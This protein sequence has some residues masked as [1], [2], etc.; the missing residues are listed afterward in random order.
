[1]GRGGR[2]FVLQYG[3]LVGLVRL[4]LDLELACLLE[5]NQI[6]ELLYSLKCT[7]KTYVLSEHEDCVLVVS[8]GSNGLVELG[9]DDL[10]GGWGNIRYLEITPTCD[11]L[12]IIVGRC[13]EAHIVIDIVVLVISDEDSPFTGNILIQTLVKQ[14][15]RRRIKE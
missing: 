2:C 1:M 10:I 4:D 11:E 7:A 13:G 3:D 15:Q 14:L 6:S 8:L 12:T 9:I 5:T